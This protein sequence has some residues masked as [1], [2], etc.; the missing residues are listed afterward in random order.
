MRR[1]LLCLAILA[2]HHLAEAPAP[3]TVA[4]CMTDSECENGPDPLNPFGDD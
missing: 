2:G 1:L 4:G 3:S